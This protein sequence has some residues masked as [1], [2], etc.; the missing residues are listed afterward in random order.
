MQKHPVASGDATHLLQVAR[1]RIDF[2]LQR[3]VADVATIKNQR[4]FVRISA[5]GNV[6]IDVNAGLWR[7]EL[8]GEA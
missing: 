5:S 4:C 7:A 3:A 1:Q 8:V 6:E 2:F